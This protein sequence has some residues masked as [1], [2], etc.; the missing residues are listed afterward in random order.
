MWCPLVESS[1]SP[2][3][4]PLAILEKLVAAQITEESIPFLPHAEPA[5]FIADIGCCDC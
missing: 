5:V 4:P 3:P 2:C 1:L